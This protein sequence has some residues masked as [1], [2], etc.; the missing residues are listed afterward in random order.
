MKKTFNHELLFGV[1]TIC[2]FVTFLSTF[3]YTVVANAAIFSNNKTV[4]A[5]DTDKDKTPT[6]V[7]LHNSETT[8]PDLSRPGSEYKS[9]PAHPERI[10][11]RRLVRTTAEII[12][13]HEGFSAT[14]YKCTSGKWTIGYGKAL[15]SI[16]K[17]TK[18]VTEKQAYLW[19]LSDV[20]NIIETLNKDF[21][22][23]RSMD[24]PRKQAMINLVYNVGT[25]GIYKFKNYLAAVEQGDYKTAAKE[26]L[27]SG[28]RKTKY[29]RQVGNRAVHLAHA[30]KYGTWFNDGGLIYS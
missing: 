11:H 19:L 28:D 15:S 20:E 1:F 13:V 8:S 9:L 24:V 23:W 4:I 21:P 16:K 22:W 6:S 5:E 14:P 18:Q 25:A 3:S 17:G 12:K 10:S 27:Y 29:W 7:A 2:C 26:I 30:M